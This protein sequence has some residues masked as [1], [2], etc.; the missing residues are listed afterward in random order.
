MRFASAS[1]GFSLLMAD[2]LKFAETGGC[3]TLLAMT[4]TLLMETVVHQTAPLKRDT[5]AL[6]ELPPLHPS[7][8]SL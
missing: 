8:H 1:P 6:M 2:A 5:N 3:L 4:I 7:A